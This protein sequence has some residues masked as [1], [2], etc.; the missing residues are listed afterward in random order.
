MF[1]IYLKWCT[2]S[3]Q[4]WETLQLCALIDKK[5][6]IL[7]MNSKMFLNKHIKLNPIVTN[8]SGLKKSTKIDCEK[9]FAV[10]F[11]SHSRIYTFK[12]HSL[13]KIDS[14]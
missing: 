1:P 13:L 8:I 14:S 11:A 7:I 2:V 9:V 6:Y 12:M 3:F 5:K 10:H 4:N